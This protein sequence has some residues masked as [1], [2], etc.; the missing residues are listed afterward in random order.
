[1]RARSDQVKV[2]SLPVYLINKQPV[3]T[4]MTL[5][6]ALKL[7]TKAMIPTGFI[8]RVPFSQ[9]FDNCRNRIAIKPLLNDSF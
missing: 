1:M 3:G 5:A 6:T 8:Q 9:L 2:Q 7:S 4:D